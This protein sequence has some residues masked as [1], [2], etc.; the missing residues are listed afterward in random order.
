MRGEGIRIV[1]LTQIV[2]HLEEDR[3]AKGQKSFV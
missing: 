1:S 2:L 3:C